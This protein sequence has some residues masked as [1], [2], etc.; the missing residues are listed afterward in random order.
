MRAAAAI[1]RRVSSP[2]AA[3]TVATDIAHLRRPQIG[4]PPSPAFL[5]TRPWPWT[6]ARAPWVGAR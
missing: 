3:L 6:R 4:P 1:A 5:S 2:A